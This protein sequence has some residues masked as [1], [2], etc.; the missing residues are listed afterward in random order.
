[1]IPLKTHIWSRKVLPYF[2]IGPAVIL[3]LIFKIYPIFNTF[4]DS[5]TVDGAFSLQ[6]FR[7][8]F[9]DKFFWESFWVTIKFNIIL[10]PLQI[11]LS[12]LVSL[13]VNAKVRGIGVFRTIYYLPAT[14]ST[15]VAAIIW[16][17]MLNPNNGV[18][19]SILSL[20]GIDKQ[21]FLTSSDQALYCIMLITTWIGVGYWMMF[22]L[23]GLKGVDEAIYD[24][25]KID[26]A[27]WFQTTVRITI[28]MIRKTLAFVLISDTTINL[29]MFAPM[30]IITNGGPRRST[31][32]LMY[33]A[34]KSYFTYADKG[35]GDAIVAVLLVMI[36]IVVTFQYFFVNGSDDEKPARRR[37]G[38]R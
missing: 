7:N 26:G 25:A 34:Y 16:G 29:L 36:A 15:A 14:M 3:I 18:I 9:S 22:I 27:N 21:P 23:A 6:N 2:L 19:N 17:T 33:E 5:M 13:L 24:S 30:Q 20:I 32:V 28:P 8:L 1:M 11:F 12:L 35:R 38:K 10:T 4:A 31:N 37:K